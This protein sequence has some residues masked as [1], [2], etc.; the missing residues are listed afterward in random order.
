MIDAKNIKQALAIDVALSTPMVEAMTLWVN[1][2]RNKSPWLGNNISSMNL[3]AAIASE[4]ARTVTIEMDVE[5]GESDRAKFLLEQFEPVMNQIRDAVEWG[6]AKGGLMF[7]PFIDGEEIKVDIVQADQFYPIHSD[8]SG[9]I[10]AAVFVNYQRVGKWYYTRLEYHNVKGNLNVEDGQ[11]KQ[12]G[13]IVQNKAYRGEAPDSLGHE[14][15]LEMVD[16]WKDLLP[17]ATIEN[18]EVPLFA[19]FK[20]PMANNINS[21]SPLGV[22]CYSRATDLI[23]QADKQW[24]SFLW[25][26]KS[27]ERAVFVDSLAF[28]RDDEGKPIIPNKRLYRTLET[29]S[30]EGELF[31]DWTPDIREEE[32]LNALEATLKRI[33]FTCGLATG[34]LSNPQT[35]DKTAT[36]IKTSKQRTAAT[37]TDTQKS[38]SK[39]LDALFLAMEAWADLEGL[40]GSGEIEPVYRYDDLIIVDKD[41]QFQQ[42]PEIGHGSDYVQG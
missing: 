41:A 14:V 6:C 5:L 13:Y 1:M 3:A 36:E 21:L 33:E 38:L 27:G 39:A 40:G 4:I 19:Y 15:P 12:T 10:L 28:A 9:N 7:K 37:I 25:E 30:M 35:I 23:E 34:T 29:G 17:E 20:Y 31:K 22:S 24:S 42:D 18:V 8:S 32:L 16:E 26:V 2:Y 11:E